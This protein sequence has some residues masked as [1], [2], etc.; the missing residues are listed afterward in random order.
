MSKA[1][2]DAFYKKVGEDE[3][4]KNKLMALKGPSKDVQA[5]V[6]QLAKD[7]GYDVEP[8]DFKG[9]FVKDGE[10]DDAAVAQV[11]GGCSGNNSGC[12][13]VCGTICSD[14]LGIYNGQQ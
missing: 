5:K 10:L 13:S 12:T 9:A 8:A 3:A 6:V 4:L 7:E 14:N 1:Q 2:F 11:A